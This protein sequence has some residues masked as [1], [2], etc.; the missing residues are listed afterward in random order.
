MNSIDTGVLIR[1]IRKNASQEEIEQVHLWLNMS[2]DNRKMFREIQE[3]YSTARGVSLHNEVD[4]KIAWNNIENKTINKTR[5][6]TKHWLFKVA[7]VIIPTVLIAGIAMLLTNNPSQEQIAF[8]PLPENCKA[9]ITLENG[10]SYELIDRQH[11]IFNISEEMKLIKDT[12]NL[13]TTSGV[14]ESDIDFTIT[15]PVGGDFNLQLSD[16]SHVWLNSVTELTYPLNFNKEKRIISVSGEIYLE[17]NRN[18]KRPFIV[19]TPTS[20]VE[21]LGTTFN[22]RAYQNESLNEITL[23]EGSVEVRSNAQRKILI[24]G[25]QAICSGNDNINVV[26][27]NVDD[28]ISW[29]N[30]VIE[31]DSGTLER[32]TNSLERWHNVEFIYDE[33]DIQYKSITGALKK[34]T[35]LHTILGYLGEVCNV[36]FDQNNNKIHVKNKISENAVTSSDTK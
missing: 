35:P 19:K 23:V 25:H 1:Y 28:H 33:D 3:V 26:R 29:I 15:T 16:G 21:V 18:K 2:V 12:A 34:E 5:R 4:E 9:Y 6:I 31:L 20:E 32:F 30:G 22:V 27:V 10:S 36:E 11:Q 13:F 17:V 8:N 7:A 14:R 24:P